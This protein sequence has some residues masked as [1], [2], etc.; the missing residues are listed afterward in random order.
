[1][2]EQPLKPHRLSLS[3]LKVGHPDMIGK[4]AEFSGYV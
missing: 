3:M 2:C 1:M 4:V